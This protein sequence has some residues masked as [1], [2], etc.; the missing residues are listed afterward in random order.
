MEGAER[1]EGDDAAAP[2]ATFEPVSRGERLADKVASA[3]TESIISGTIAVGERLPPERELCERFGVSRPVIREAVRSLIAKGLLADHSRRGHVVTAFGREAVTESLTFYLRGERLDY[4]KLMEVRMLI[5]IENAGL[6]A[7]RASSAQIAALRDAAARLEPDPDVERVALQDLA[8]HRAIATATD[9]EFLEVLHDSLREALITAQLPTLADPRI[10]ASA[11]RAHE[12]VAQQIQ[13][14]NAAGARKAMRQHLEEAREG[15][16][17]LL[18]PPER[19]ARK[20]TPRKRSRPA[21]TGSQRV[22]GSAA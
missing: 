5:E 1:T 12:R 2:I 3:L 15:L 19:P 11:R 21:R 10:V 18:R 20:G 4:G 6:A 22:G 17:A 7:E 16:E 9:N 14:R 13:A 8:F